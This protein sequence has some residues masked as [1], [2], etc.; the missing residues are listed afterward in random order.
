MPPS[1]TAEMA[2]I[3]NIRWSATGT[4]FSENIVPALLKPFD[5]TEMV[6]ILSKIDDAGAIVPLMAIREPY[7]TRFVAKDNETLIASLHADVDESS[8]SVTSLFLGSLFRADYELLTID[9]LEK[10]AEDITLQYSQEEIDFIEAKTRPQS[11][12][13]LWYRFRCGRVTGSTF[14]S[15]CRTSVETPAMS[16]IEKICFPESKIF[17][18]TA[19]E[20]GKFNEPIAKK[21]YAR[22]MPEEDH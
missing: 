9:D 7:A 15:V 16:L 12:S 8:L 19:T 13:R 20:Y 18:S 14:K 10:V 21:Q 3:K 4:P 1:K 11:E 2:K 22:S 5:H 17:T 6:D